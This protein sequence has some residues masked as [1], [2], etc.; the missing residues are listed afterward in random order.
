M[1][2]A[3]PSTL[4]TVNSSSLL[5]HRASMTRRSRCTAA[6]AGKEEALGPAHEYAKQ[7]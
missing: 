5:K 1:R 2:A 3:H 4:D 7:C 6:L